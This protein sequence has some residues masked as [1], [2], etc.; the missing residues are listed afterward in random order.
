MILFLQLDFKPSIMI[1]TDFSGIQNKL[2]NK[3]FSTDVWNCHFKI[4]QVYFLYFFFGNPCFGGCLP[5]N[6]LLEYQWKVSC[7]EDDTNAPKT[8]RTQISLRNCALCFPVTVM[9]GL[10][11][12]TLSPSYLVKL[13][14]VLAVKLCK[15]A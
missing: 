6:V 11:F 8:N 7:E 14:N 12:Q 2:Q 13:L 3:F 5:L 15:V 10:C 9:Q 1:S 4:W